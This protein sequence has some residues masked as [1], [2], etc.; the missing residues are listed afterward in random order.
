MFERVSLLKEVNVFSSNNTARIKQPIVDGWIP[1]VD[2]LPPVE[3]EVLILVK[4]KR[5]V[6]SLEWDIAG[7][8]DN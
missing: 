4:S 5:R 2:E 1:C 8:E 6:G 3:T 7:V